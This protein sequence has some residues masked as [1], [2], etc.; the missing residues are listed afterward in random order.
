MRENAPWPS[1]APIIPTG[2]RSTRESFFLDDEPR[3]LTSIINELEAAGQTDVRDRL[4]DETL[5]YPRRHPR[6]FYWY[7]KRLNEDE[8]LADKATYAV[9]FQILDALTQR[10][11]LRRARAAQG[12]LR[13]GRPGR[14]HR[15]EPEQRGAGPPARGDARPLRRRR[16]VPPRDRQGGR[17]DEVSRRCASRRPSRSTPPPSRW[18]GSAASCMHLKNVEIPANSKALQ[19]AREMGDLRENFEYK[20]ARARAEFLSARVGELASRDLARARARPGSRST[21]PSVRVGTKLQLSNGDARRDVAIL[22]PWESEPEHGVYSNRVR[23]G[24]EADGPRRRRRGL[25]HGQRLP[26]RVASASGTSDARMSRVFW[27]GGTS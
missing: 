6:A 9:L 7:V 20:A 26:D 25:V 16:G 12:P 1:S 10:R 5:R 15:H 21:P 18:S 11:V 22:G 19:A 27:S 4:I 17:A 23:R 14:A 2:R 3:I 13:Q 24:Q 8:S